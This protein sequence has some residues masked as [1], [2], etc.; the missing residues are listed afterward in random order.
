M[1]PPT[2]DVWQHSIEKMDVSDE[3]Y[4]CVR[5]SLTFR[6]VK[7][8]T[9]NTLNFAPLKLCY[10][11]ISHVEKNNDIITIHFKPLTEEEE[12]K[13]MTEDSEPVIIRFPSVKEDWKSYKDIT[14]F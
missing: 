1:N 4:N 7:I 3:N 6:N 5:F 13:T 12:E 10:S 8:I 14:D 9:L 2:N 11:V